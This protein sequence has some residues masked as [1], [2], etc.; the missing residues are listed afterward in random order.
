MYAHSLEAKKNLDPAFFTLAFD[1]ATLRPTYVN[2]LL[3][4]YYS[5][6][7]QKTKSHVIKTDLSDIGFQCLQDWSVLMK[8]PQLMNNFAR[9]FPQRQGT[10]YTLFTLACYI[11]TSM[12]TFAKHFCLKS[13]MQHPISVTG[14][15]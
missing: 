4:I 10:N 2:I 1:S 8:M 15:R 3:Y 6:L 14:R 12:S 7:F 5:D 11:A 9:I 13:F